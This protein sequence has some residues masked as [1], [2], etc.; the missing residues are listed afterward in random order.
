[1]NCTSGGVHMHMLVDNLY[2]VQHSQVEGGRATGC[3]SEG[4]EG[5]QRLHSLV[6]LIC[7]SS[8]IHNLKDPNLHTRH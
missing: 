4:E 5:L 1:M 6:C 8:Q 3:I 2:A 7:S